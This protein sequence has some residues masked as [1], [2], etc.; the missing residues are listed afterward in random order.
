MIDS[1]FDGFQDPNYEEQQNWFRQVLLNQEEDVAR[2]TRIRGMMAR[3]SCRIVARYEEKNE[4]LNPASGKG[5]S[6]RKA[7]AKGAM[8]QGSSSMAR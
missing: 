4:K 1:R 2:W 8:G 3:G 7:V 5:S 6:R